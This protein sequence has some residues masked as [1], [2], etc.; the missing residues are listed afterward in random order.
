MSAPLLPS[1]LDYVG[2]R[3]FVF[4][5]P[6]SHP[7]PN[8]RPDPNE[9]MLG[10]GAHF[11]VQVV[12]A[13]TGREIW[14]PRQFIGAVSETNTSLLIVGLTRALRLRDGSIEPKE[15]QIIEMPSSSTLSDVPRSVAPRSLRPG[16]VV[17]IRLESK[18]TFSLRKSLVAACTGAVVVALLAALV[19]ASIRF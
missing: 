6:L 10:L 1:P 13:H 16:A 8:D 18:P 9:W 2:R 5:P 14:V 19:T 17:G 15:K 3:R 11:E 12:N 4:Y 7:D